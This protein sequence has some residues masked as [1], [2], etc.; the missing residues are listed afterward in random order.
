MKIDTSSIQGKRDNIVRTFRIENPLAEEHPD[1]VF[2]LNYD[3]HDDLVLRYY[4]C[5]GT[6]IKNYIQA[7]IFNPEQNCFF[8]D[9][10]ISCLANP[11]FYMAKKKITGFYIAYGGGDGSQLEWI[12]GSWMVTKQFSVCNEL[13]SSKWQ[14]VY[15]LRMDTIQIIRPY[16]MIPPSDILETNMNLSVYE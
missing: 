10:L 16:M 15:P 4:G 11:T 12:S 5:C 7:Y 2:D 1:T 14:V 3:G 9:T 13:D 8:Y 6:G